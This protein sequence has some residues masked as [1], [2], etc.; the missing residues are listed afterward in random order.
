MTLVAM[1][2]LLTSCKENK[3]NDEEFIE[4]PG[5]LLIQFNNTLLQDFRW[6][7]EHN[8]LV[9]ATVDGLYTLDV[10]T[11]T[12]TQ[13]DEGFIL[14][15]AMAPDETKVYYFI[16]NVIPEEQPIWV[17][18]LRSGEK[19]I[20]VDQA[21]TN[22]I[23]VSHGL[24]S[25]AAYGDTYA[26]ENNSFLITYLYDLV[27]GTRDS[28]GFGYPIAV[29]PE[30][31]KVLAKHEKGQF[32]VDVYLRDVENNTSEFLDSDIGYT[33][34]WDENGLMIAEWDGGDLLVKD[35]FSGT[36]IR[37]LEGAPL[38][39]GEVLRPW[40]NDKLTDF[41]LYRSERTSRSNDAEIFDYNPST[42]EITPIASV[43]AGF[44]TTPIRKLQFAESINSII[45]ESGISNVFS[46]Y[47]VELL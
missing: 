19:K 6:S 43:R 33:N 18:D 15:I 21:F 10:D 26:D 17:Y 32:D 34:I 46:L 3:E 22:R 24:T 31:T 47:L 39:N 27:N 23:V 36:E 38:W 13:V 9:Y 12:S 45:Y 40:F 2:I 41:I 35:F 4:D 25:L 8:L 11:K 7:N 28:I 37:R 1:V 14:M 44:D 5:E 30:G 29:N 20:A 42:Q 16:S